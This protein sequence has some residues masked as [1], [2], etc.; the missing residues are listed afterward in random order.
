MQKK[1]GAIALLLALIALPAFA[2]NFE[3]VPHPQAVFDTT[4]GTLF[5]ICPPGQASACDPVVDTT[6]HPNADQQI[7][8]PS[9][10]QW[11]CSYRASQ[12]LRVC[13]WRDLHS[14][15]G[16]FGPDNATQPRG[17]IRRHP[18]CGNGNRKCLQ[19]RGLGYHH[20]SKRR[21]PRCELE[22]CD[23]WPD[24]WRECGNRRLV[25]WQ[26]KHIPF[27]ADAVRRVSA[28]GGFKGDSSM[29]RYRDECLGV[30]W[31]IPG[32]D[33]PDHT[34]LRLHDLA[35]PDQTLALLALSLSLL[36]RAFDAQQRP[37]H[38]P[39]PGGTTLLGDLV[40]ATRNGHRRGCLQRDGAVVPDSGI[41]GHRHQQRQLHPVPG[42]ECL[43]SN[44][45]SPSSALTSANG[46]AL[47]VTTSG[48]DTSGYAG[49]PV[50]TATTGYA[51]FMIGPSVCWG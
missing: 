8:H 26:R 49:H 43:L 5:S 16:K 44:A 36:A 38:Q 6:E 29:S 35:D 23:P 4:L 47:N 45:A 2:D 30:Q 3:T 22:R 14:D 32:W 20:W 31:H 48:P 21:N 41:R 1:I 37:D 12:S 19:F 10:D 25:R 51:A 28:Q 24:L 42:L 13:L 15:L 50:N 9:D 11:R 40:P 18:S 34:L 33:N 17:R 39:P 46:I 27:V 7:A